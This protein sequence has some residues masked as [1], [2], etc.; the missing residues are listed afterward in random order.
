VSRALE[1]ALTALTSGDV[2]GPEK[3]ILLGTIVG[4]VIP[5]REGADVVFA[6]GLPGKAGGEDVAD[7]AG[8]RHTFHTTCV[9]C[10]VRM[11]VCTLLLNERRSC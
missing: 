1:D 11:D 8:S 4:R 9:V 2:I 3:R 7:A 5:H 6:P 10:Q